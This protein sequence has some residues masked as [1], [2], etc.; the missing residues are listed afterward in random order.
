[1]A[2]RLAHKV[3]LITG[4]GSGMGREMALLFAR[5]GAIVVI[6]DID[7][8]AGEKTA[9]ERRRDEPAFDPRDRVP[10]DRSHAP[11]LAPAFAVHLTAFAI[12]CAA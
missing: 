11:V 5:E 7:E 6:N 9:S 10:D 2:D 12:I 8:E 1:M 3:A 4:A